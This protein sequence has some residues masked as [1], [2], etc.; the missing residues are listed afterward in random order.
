METKMRI[1]ILCENLVGRLAG[2]G[3]HGLSVFIESSRGNYLFDTG[4][5][6]GIV[7]NSLALSSMDVLEVY[8][9]FKKEEL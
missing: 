1:T 7:A 5:G 8:W 3:E 2:W 9:K 6:H 4:N